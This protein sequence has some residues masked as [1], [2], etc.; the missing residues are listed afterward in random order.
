MLSLLQSEAC[1]HPVCKEQGRTP[2][3]I[4]GH[5]EIGPDGSCGKFSRLGTIGRLATANLPD[6]A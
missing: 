2:A 4:V 1:V 5:S 3:W 6:G